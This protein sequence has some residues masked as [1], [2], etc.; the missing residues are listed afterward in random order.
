MKK[1]L[2]GLLLLASSPALAQTP[3]TPAV[4]A[5]VCAFNTVPP[6]P[7]AGQFYYVQCDSS[8]K[9]ITSGSGG[10][11]SP[12]GSNTQVQYN[13]SGA[14]GGITGA[15]TDGTTLTLV[16]PNLG[17]P[18]SATLTSAIGLPISTGLV[19]AGTGVLTALSVNI[20][21]AGSFVVNGGAL[22]TPS[23]GVATNLTGTAAGLTAGNVTTNANLTGDVTSVGNAT[24]YNNLVGVAKG[25][26]GIAS[27]T[28]GGIPYY[29]A[30]ATIASS[31]ALTANAPV[32][33]GGAGVAPTVG[34]R[35]G[36]T[37][38][39]ATTTGTLTS[40]NCAKFDASG[41]IVDAATTCGGGGGSG[42]VTSV[43]VTTANGVS[44]SVANPTTTPALTFTLGAISPSSVTTNLFIPPTDSTTAIQ[45]TKANGTTVVGDWDTTNSRFGI[46]GTPTGTFQVFSPV[47]SAAVTSIA[48]TPATTTAVGS[49][50]SVNA[51]VGSFVIRALSTAASN[52]NLSN[53][54][55][56]TQLQAN[57][58]QSGG[59]IIDSQAAA[60]IIFASGG[61]SFTNERMRIL[62]SAASFIYGGPD[63]AAPGA[64]TFSMQN[65]VAGNTNT[66]AANTTFNGS[67]SN[68]SGAGGDFIF[69]TTNNVAS[70]GVQNTELATLTIKGG[71][72]HIAYGGV[73]PAV[74]ACGTGSPAIDANATDSSGNVTTG[75]VAT[76]CTVTF[77]KPYTS[78]N[79]CLVTS[80][81]T[82]SG[83]AYSY[84]L[85]AITIAA[86]VLGGDL[87]DYRCDGV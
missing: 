51:D 3:T 67:L 29:S 44:A 2:I 15:T 31:A 14:F 9:L 82:V 86:S 48:F 42:T 25:G 33:G 34:T 77:A 32:I 84:T 56:S 22:G 58:A 53:V 24:S 64:V 61:A 57:S 72:Q 26:T 28:S 83:L 20:G 17:T 46:N 35:S 69:N 5:L 66:A 10:G 40:G 80:Q 87:L 18:A 75:T 27:G 41:N 47:G 74:S 11:G 12:G 1:L 19:G 71:T 13:N 65:V 36:N 59:L 49:I 70:S 50:V 43:S 7:A 85:S 81:T 30:S 79:H 55:L 52:A 16:A 38:T 73:K 68:G 8:G 60:P 78:Y 45:V 63:A 54:P 76:S 21:T 37:T 6:T 4:A 39:F 62:S 23:S